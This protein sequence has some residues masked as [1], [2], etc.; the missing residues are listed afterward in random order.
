MSTTAGLGSGDYAAISPLAVATTVIALIGLAS[1]FSDALLLIPAAAIVC[2]L[3]ALRQIR[4][5]NGTLTGTYIAL[6]GIALG[7]GILVTI[8]GGKLLADLRVR[9]SKEKILGIISTFN[10]QVA[11]HDFSAAYELCSPTLKANVTREKW[12]ETFSLFDTVPEFGGLAGVEWNGTLEFSDDPEARKLA[13][14]GVLL[15]YRKG[16][17]PGRSA[18]QFS[19]EGDRWAIEDIPNLLP[20]KKKTP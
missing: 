11:N 2:G 20:R 17:M 18:I 3:F 19:K 14:A 12:I 10:K 9:P 6:I 15:K 7:I 1:W 13:A 5:S 8:G 16:G 4:R